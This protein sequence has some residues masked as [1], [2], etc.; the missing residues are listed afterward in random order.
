MMYKYV[1]GPID[2][3]DGLPTLKEYEMMLAREAITNL[4]YQKELAFQPIV[5]LS[6]QFEQAKKEMY[7]WEGDFLAGPYV[8]L[9]PDPDSV[10]MQPGF[11]WKQRN[12]GTTFIVSPFDL[13]WLNEYRV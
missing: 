4:A 2:Y 10:T 5:F 6:E 1:T 12:N 13:P 8:F 7:C 3:W 9:L 11:I